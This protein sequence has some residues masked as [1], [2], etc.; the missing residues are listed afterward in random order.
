MP[1]VLVSTWVE[2]VTMAYPEALARS[3]GERY[4]TV[5]VLIG[6]PAAAL[7]WA[8]S[9]IDASERA[10]AEALVLVEAPAAQ[11]A[12]I[13]ASQLPELPDLG[14]DV[15][16]GNLDTHY[17]EGFLTSGERDHLR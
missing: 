7:S 14:I 8:R 13:L 12:P 9:F 11:R 2:R 17:D 4:A 15:N 6:E 3:L 5:L 10:R 1:D 16:L